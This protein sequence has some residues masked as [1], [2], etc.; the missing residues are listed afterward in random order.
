MTSLIL[1]GQLLVLKACSVN[2]KILVKFCK[3]REITNALDISENGV[4]FEKSECA[5]DNSSINDCDFKGII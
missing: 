4:M 3:Q 5:D 2:H 1:V